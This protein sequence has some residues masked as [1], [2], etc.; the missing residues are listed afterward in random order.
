MLRLMNS[1]CADTSMETGYWWKH[2][3]K[4]V[5]E[6]Q[7]FRVVDPKGEK[8][9]ISVQV[10]PQGK[11]EK[12]T[13]RKMDTHTRTSETALVHELVLSPK[14]PPR[15]VFYRTG[16]RKFQ[17]QGEKHVFVEG[18]GSYSGRQILP[19]KSKGKGQVTFTEV[20][21]QRGPVKAHDEAGVKNLISNLQKIADENLSPEIR[22]HVLTAIE[23]HGH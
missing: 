19:Q 23:L 1:R 15:G 17:K 2:E 22:K 6:S 8:Q 4:P 14:H 9:A 3:V 10:G 20:P 16:Y 5:G 21:A 13:F 12:L 7:E 18:A 11:I